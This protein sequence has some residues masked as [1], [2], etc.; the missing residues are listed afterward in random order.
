MKALKGFALLKVPSLI[1]ERP[2]PESEDRVVELFRN[3]AELKKAYG[4]AQT[5]IDRLKDRLKQ[6]EGATQRVQEM[7]EVLEVRLGATDTAFPAVVF[8]HLRSLW[9]RGRELIEERVAELS[10]QNE[11]RERKAHLAEFNR[12][13]FAKR[14]EIEAQVSAAEADCVRGRQHLQELEERRGKLTRFWHYF[15]RRD[16]IA[17]IAIAARMGE[18]NAASL[19][20]A[21]EAVEVLDATA[22]GEFPG[23]SIDA[24]RAIN[25]A[26]IAYA[27]IL[28]V[29]LARTPLVRLAREAVGR[30]EATDDYGTRA[31]CETCIAEI[32]RARAL[33]EQ[34][35]TLAEELRARLDRLRKLVRYR[36]AQDTTP[37]PDTLAPG[38]GTDAPI[39]V[40]ADDAWDL[41][42]ILLR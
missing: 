29:R 31:E 19:A 42:R 2:A 13:Q 4:A 38:S 23:L 11:D 33:I 17:D 35:A 12:R 28:C 16:L 27:E 6:Q 36:S 14:Q 25:L 8:Y 41:F 39:N 32:A 5:E 18:E 34:N 3:R 24:R 10:R 20:R 37:I 15:K 7:L 9:Q 22:A 1:P 40:L 26:A 21:R 30:R